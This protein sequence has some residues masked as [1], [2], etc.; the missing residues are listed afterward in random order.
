MHWEYSPSLPTSALLVRWANE[1]EL[2]ETHFHANQNFRGLLLIT[3][4]KV[5]V[6]D[7]H[8]YERKLIT[9]TSKIANSCLG[10]T[11]MKVGVVYLHR[12]PCSSWNV[13]GG[14]GVV[15]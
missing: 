10:P 15:L 2:P 14:Q 6:I 12:D 8:F 13:P 1:L 11:V 3:S 7:N 4:S 9:Q 5:C